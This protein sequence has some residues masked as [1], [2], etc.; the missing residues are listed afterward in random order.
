MIYQ[1]AVDVAGELRAAL[2]HEM[3]SDEAHT[4]VL[5]SATPA[6]AHFDVETV[7]G[8]TFRVTV[9]RIQPEAVP[10]GR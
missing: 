2:N 9:T 10:H 7:E 8:K 5:F 4:G 6:D 1:T 3:V